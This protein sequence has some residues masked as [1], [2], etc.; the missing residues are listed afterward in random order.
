MYFANFILNTAPLHPDL[1]K[2]RSEYLDSNVTYE[3]VSKL[4]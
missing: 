3:L 4:M 1:L 2:S